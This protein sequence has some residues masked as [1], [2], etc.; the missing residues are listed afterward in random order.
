MNH[1]PEIATTGHQNSTAS[2]ARRGGL[3]ANTATIESATTAGAVESFVRIRA[4]ETTPRPPTSHFRSASRRLLSSNATNR[5]ASAPSVLTRL[6]LFTT[7]E[8]NVNFGTAATKAAAVTAV[9]GEPEN[10]SAAAAVRSSVSR[11][12]AMLGA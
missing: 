3:T 6:S 7:A 4:P 5:I 12:R 10:L 11:P 2:A 8:R 1:H 9:Q